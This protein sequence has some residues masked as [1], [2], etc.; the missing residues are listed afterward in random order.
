[1]ILN[2]LIQYYLLIN[3]YFIFLLLDENENENEND[4]IDY[5]WFF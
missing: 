3:T 4:L 5:D 1:M 2:K